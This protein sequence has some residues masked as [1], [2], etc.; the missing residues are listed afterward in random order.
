VI[1]TGLPLM[2]AQNRAFRVVCIVVVLL[3]FVVI[4]ADVSAAR[5]FKPGN[6]A[7][8]RA[9][10]IE[11]RLEI[12]DCPR[13]GTRERLL[14]YSD[15][16]GA[17]TLAEVVNPFLDILSPLLAF[18]RGQSRADVV[19]NPGLKSC[20]FSGNRGFV[21]FPHCHTLQVKGWG[22]Q[23]TTGDVSFIILR[24]K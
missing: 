13:D 24:S 8:F 19:G 17:D 15:L 2:C 9:A 12:F 4:C 22:N 1:F 16:T 14:A 23:M 7:G 11:S 20:R 21:G 10:R 6:T 18:N 3:G 5:Y